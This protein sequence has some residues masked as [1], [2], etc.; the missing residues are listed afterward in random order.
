MLCADMN[1]NAAHYNINFYF[2]FPDDNLIIRR[3][4][5]AS[6]TIVE[7]FAHWLGIELHHIIPSVS[8]RHARIALEL[9]VPQGKLAGLEAKVNDVISNLPDKNALEKCEFGIAGQQLIKLPEKSV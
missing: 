7:S 3:I 4:D 6:N 8:Y 1:T 2:N 5:A 9:P